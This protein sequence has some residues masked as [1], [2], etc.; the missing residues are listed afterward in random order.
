MDDEEDDEVEQ[1][2][3]IAR[4]RRVAPGIERQASDMG[5][6]TPAGKETDPSVKAVTQGVKEVELESKPKEEEHV[7]NAEPASAAV[8]AEPSS[9]VATAA[10]MPLPEADDAEEAALA[11][12][13]SS[14]PAPETRTETAADPE[15][16]AS[17]I[18]A[19]AAEVIAPTP[20]EETQDA[21]LAAETKDEQL[22]T[23]SEDAIAT[24]V[25]AAAAQA[26][27]TVTI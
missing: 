23:T 8:E 7:E 4:K 27:P 24:V 16:P 25:A 18:T 14:S 6:L 12:Q 10:E 19:A 22:T 17:P 1:T 3:S 20:L 21:P 2:A 26:V 15:V 13:P 11:K 5:E 9:A